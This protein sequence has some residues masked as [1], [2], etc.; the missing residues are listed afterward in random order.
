[1]A[2]VVRPGE[3]LTY[4]GLMLSDVPSCAA[5]VGY[6]NASWTP[7][8]ELSA[9]HV[10]RLLR[11][12]DRRGYEVCVPRCERAA[13]GARPLLGLTSGS[14]RRA[15]RVVKFTRAGGS[16]SSPAASRRPTSS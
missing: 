13:A 14:V 7:R 9:R 5:C 4:E 3:L 11:H 10:C 2:A 15:D 8:A 12:T 6:T 1:M 16:C